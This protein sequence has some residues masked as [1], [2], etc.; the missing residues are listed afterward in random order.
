MVYTNLVVCTGVQKP[1]FVKSKVG[2]K[3]RN[4]WGKFEKI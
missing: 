4:F 2:K 1:N 3:K